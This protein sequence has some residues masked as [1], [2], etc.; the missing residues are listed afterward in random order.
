MLI[1]FLNYIVYVSFHPCIHLYMWMQLSTK[2]RNCVRFHLSGVS[3]RCEPCNLC[4]ETKLES[5]E[6]A[7]YNLN[8]CSVFSASFSP[9][10]SPH[11]LGSEPVF[12]THK[13][14]LSSSDFISWPAGV[15]LTMFLPLSIAEMLVLSLPRRFLGFKSCSLRHMCSNWNIGISFSLLCV[16]RTEKAVF[17]SA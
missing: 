4:L 17:G 10:S 6:R 1:L 8:P 7:L 15:I 3:G 2:S 16:D 14:H 9:V 12:Y 13:L 11:S 5:S